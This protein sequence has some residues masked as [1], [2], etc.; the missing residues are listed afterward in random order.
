MKTSNCTSLSVQEV[1][2]LLAFCLNATYLEFQGEFYQQTFG[3]TMGCPVSVTVANLVMEDVERRAMTTT[4]VH[5]K[6]WK[7][8]VDDTCTALPVNR[9]QE[10]LEHLNSV[11]PII[12]F[13][14]EKESEGKLPFLDV[15]LK[16]HR[17][18]SIST[19]VVQKAHPHE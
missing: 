7:R 12:Q 11:E 2:K 16:H 17:D 13:T 15:H 6:F 10:F 9:C 14:P 18:G 4:D 1:V 5:P 19:S 3:M 8:Y